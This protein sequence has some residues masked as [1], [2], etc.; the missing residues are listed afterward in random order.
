MTHL[1]GQ[2]RIIGYGGL[3][4]TPGPQPHRTVV[5]SNGLG[6]TRERC[7]Q[8]LEGRSAQREGSKEGRLLPSVAPGQLR[9]QKCAGG[10]PSNKMRFCSDVC[11]KGAGSAGP[12]VREFKPNEEYPARTHT[13]ECLTC[14]ETVT[15]TMQGLA[16]RKRRHCTN[17]SKPRPG[18]DW[19]RWAKVI[20]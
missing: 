8:C 10:V 6:S 13:F 7:Y 3:C 2:F 1:A 12:R 20:K 19:R 15:V 11:R 9:C 16:G 4:P 17:C 18:Q 5:E 14:H